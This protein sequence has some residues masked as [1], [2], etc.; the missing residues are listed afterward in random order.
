MTKKESELRYNGGKYVGPLGEVR[1]RF[2]DER[3]QEALRRMMQR[4]KEIERK[5]LESVSE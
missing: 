3:A 1:A 2:S 5:R 4:K